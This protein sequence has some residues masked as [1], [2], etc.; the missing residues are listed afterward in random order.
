MA[1]FAQWREDLSSGGEPREEAVLLELKA[2]LLRLAATI[3]VAPVARTP[4]APWRPRAER[5]RPASSGWR[6]SSPPLQDAIGLE[7]VAREVRLHPDYARRSSGRS[8]GSRR[9]AS[10][11]STASRTPS[12]C[13]S[14]AT[15]RSWRWR[16]R[17]ASGRSAASTRPSAS[18]AAARRGSTARGT[19]SDPPGAGAEVTARGD[20]G[21]AA[22]PSARPCGSFRPASEPPRERAARRARLGLDGRRWRSPMGRHLAVAAAFL[23]RGSGPRPRRSRARP[24]WT[25]SRPG[26]ASSS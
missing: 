23:G 1:R 13:S 24:S 15:P 2:R 21:R 12:G 16:W 8:S 4:P 22:R 19:A 9:P 20:D 18:S 17:P 5:P 3:R 6:P 11:S 10:F 26:R 7:E 14:R 25:R